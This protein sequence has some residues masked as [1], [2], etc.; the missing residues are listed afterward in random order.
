[1]TAISDALHH[2]IFTVSPIITQI[3]EIIG[4]GFIFIGS[5]ITLWALFKSGFDFSNRAI[6][7]RFGEILAMALQFKLGAEI[8][9]TVTIRDVSELIIL[10]IV[11][12]LRIVLTLVVHWEIKAAEESNHLENNLDN[13]KEEES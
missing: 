4:I 10:S 12:I 5:L 9:K 6:T 8:I 2:F 13:T 11:V 3:L 1:M 7:I